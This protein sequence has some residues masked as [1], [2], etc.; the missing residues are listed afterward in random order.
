MNTLPMPQ[1]P[2][3][4]MARI[5]APAGPPETLLFEAGGTTVMSVPG[6]YSVTYL[7][8]GPE[9]VGIVDVGSS[10]DVPAVLAA[11]D[12]LGRPRSQVR[13]VMPTHLHFDHILGVDKLACELGVPVLLG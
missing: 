8:L 2:R 10:S 13:W 3:P 7:V 6:L 1:A 9:A 11:L 5:T 12:W 4:L